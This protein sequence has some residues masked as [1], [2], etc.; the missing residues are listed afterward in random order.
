MIGYGVR[1]M[2]IDLDNGDPGLLI[3]SDMRERFSEIM[4]DMMEKGTYEYIRDRWGG[5]ILTHMHYKYFKIP[6][7]YMEKPFD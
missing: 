3:W 7:G 4:T 1:D 5:L 6:R 2:T